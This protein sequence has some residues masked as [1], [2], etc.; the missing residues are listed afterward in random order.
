MPEVEQQVAASGRAF[1]DEHAGA[2]GRWGRK[3]V[4]ARP[5][6]YATQL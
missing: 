2:V 1:D 4:L 3:R 6:E 5:C